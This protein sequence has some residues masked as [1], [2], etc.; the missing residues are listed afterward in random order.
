MNK[1]V[2]LIPTL[3]FTGVLAL[4]SISNALALF[5]QS[6]SEASFGIS[7]GVDYYLKGNFNDWAQDNGFKFIDNTADMGAEEHKVREYKLENIP[8]DKDNEVKIWVNNDTWITDGDN[9]TYEHHWTNSISYSD[10]GHN[11]IVPM[12]SNTYSFYLKFYDNG[13]PRLHI[14]ANKD[15]FYFI[16]SNNWLK[17]DAK[18]AIFQYNDSDVQSYIAQGAAIAES[19]IYKCELDNQYSKFKFTRRAPDYTTIWNQSNMQTLGNVDTNNC[20]AMR[21]EYYDT[22]DGIWSNWDA[23]GGDQNGATGWWSTR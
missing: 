16:P 8:L 3:I 22:S 12:T 4:G 15:V 6:A 7:Q 18:I 17:D 21:E 1:K 9:S 19:N 10:I 2:I 13:S 11:Y 5:T 14:T 23:V 20:F